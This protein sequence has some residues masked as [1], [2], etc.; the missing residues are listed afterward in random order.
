MVQDCLPQKM[1]FLTEARFEILKPPRDLWRQK[2]SV[3]G[4]NFQFRALVVPVRESKQQLKYQFWSREACF[5][6]FT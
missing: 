1:S 6:N 4:L 5:Q 3:G 2:K